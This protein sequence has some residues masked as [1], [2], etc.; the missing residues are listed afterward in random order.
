MCVKSCSIVCLCIYLHS[1][2]VGQEPTSV[3]TEGVSRPGY[4]KHQCSA[5]FPTLEEPGECLPSCV[6]SLQT[7]LLTLTGKRLQSVTLP[8]SEMDLPKISAKQKGNDD[9]ITCEFREFH[10]QEHLLVS[11]LQELEAGKYTHILE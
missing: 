7:H 11:H 6:M 5:T 1:G 8:L 3:N 2:L 9:L 10:L 4:N